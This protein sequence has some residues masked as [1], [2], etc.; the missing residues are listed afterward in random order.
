MEVKKS[1]NL[2]ARIWRIRK[3]GG[4]VQSESE[5]LRTIEI[6]VYKFQSESKGPRIRDQWC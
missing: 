1:H 2:L 5:F 3:T 6:N 4:I